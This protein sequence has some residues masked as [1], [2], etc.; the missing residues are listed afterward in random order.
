MGKSLVLEIIY[1]VGCQVSQVK[2]VTHCVCNRF[3]FES[4]G[5]TCSYTVRPNCYRNIG[6]CV[7][8]TRFSGRVRAWRSGRLSASI[9][10]LKFGRA[11]VVER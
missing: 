8:L 2:A 5:Q 9:H 10:L 4:R 1:P 11:Q 6:L 3:Y 7:E